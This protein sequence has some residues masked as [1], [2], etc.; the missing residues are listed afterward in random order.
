M[1]TATAQDV[2]RDWLTAEIAPSF[3]RTGWTKS[4]NNFH[5]RRDDMVG[6]VQL[7]KSPWSRADHLRFWIKAGIWSERLSL[8]D[9][10]VD[11]WRQGQPSRPAADECHWTIWYDTIMRPGEDWEIR[12]GAS[13]G[14]LAELG[15][16]V[17]DRLSRRVLP[18]L[19]AHLSEV[20]IR[21]ALLGGD[22]R[23]SFSGSRL[24]YLYALVAALG[25]SQALPGV[26]SNL[27]QNAPKLAERLGLA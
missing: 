17:R 6:V 27:R 5:L 12:R 14:E 3:K 9:A 7:A 4:G 1:S 13:I 26:V 2:F 21:D 22:G 24:A 23:I 8:I 20:A 18:E 11:S 19:T 25:P 16:D 15:R 10:Q